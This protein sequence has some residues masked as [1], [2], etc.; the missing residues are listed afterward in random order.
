MEME[1]PE[2]F[3]LLFTCGVI[4]NGLLRCSFPMVMWVY[5]PTALGWFLQMIIFVAPS[6]S[7]RDQILLWGMTSVVGIY[8]FANPPPHRASVDGV[9]WRGVEKDYFTYMVV[10]LMWLTLT[11]LRYPYL[12]RM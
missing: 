9:Y 3:S 8:F 10:S 12:L 5:Q 7:V 4:F 1:G 6:G 2:E 11:L